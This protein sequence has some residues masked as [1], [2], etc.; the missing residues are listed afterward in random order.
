MGTFD[1]KRSESAHRLRRSDFRTGRSDDHRVLRLRH[2]S[3]LHIEEGWI[4]HHG[5]GPYEA[6]QESRRTRLKAMGPPLRKRQRLEFVRKEPEEPV[7]LGLLLRFHLQYAINVA[8]PATVN[9]AG[10]GRGE[11]FNGHDL[12]R[13]EEIVAVGDVGDALAR[14]EEIPLDRVAR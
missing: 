9:L 1:N 12:P 14:M 13:L 6:V 4:R 11:R 3:A 7:R 8:G 10:A 2:D 5:P